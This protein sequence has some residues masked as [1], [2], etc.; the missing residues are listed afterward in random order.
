MKLKV[1]L[2][3]LLNAFPINDPY[4]NHVDFLWGLNVTKEVNDPIKG[5]LNTTDAVDWK[6]SG[7]NS[8]NEQ[9][10]ADGEETEIPSR[11]PPYLSNDLY[12]APGLDYL[13]ENLDAIIADTMPRFVYEN[14][15]EEFQRERDMQKFLFGKVIKLMKSAEKKYGELRDGLTNE[16]SDLADDTMSGISVARNAVDTHV[17]KTAT[18]LNDK[19]DHT[20]KSV[21][22]GVEK[23][24]RFVVGGVTKVEQ[25]VVSGVAK[26][27][28]SVVRG[29]AKAE[30][31]VNYG[32]NKTNDVAANV[33]YSVWSK[34]LNKMF[35]FFK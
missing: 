6:Y 33:F 18:L 14:D 23:A 22:F 24:Q 19:V 13:V 4:C 30:Y 35:R 26:A 34:K 9:D 11:R 16:I 21:V 31:Y 17:K 12:S 28:Q 1:Q 27:E 20:G 25:S 2:P 10:V 15:V 32:L 8:P 7:P 5:I 3:K 29:V